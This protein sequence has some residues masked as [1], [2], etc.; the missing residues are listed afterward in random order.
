MEF[1]DNL[2][3]NN[4]NIK[5]VESTPDYLQLILVDNDFVPLL[6][7]SIVN[8]KSFISFIVKQ[9][10]RRIKDPKANS[11]S[12]IVAEK[13]FK[14][15]IKNSDVLNISFFYQLVKKEEFSKTM[16]VDL[17]YDDL[18][19][20]EIVELIKKI[21]DIFNFV[22]PEKEFKNPINQYYKDLI[23][24]GIIEQKDLKEEEKRSSLTEEEEIFL[25]IEMLLPAWKQ[26][27]ELGSEKDAK[28]FL[29]KLLESCENILKSMELNEDI[30]KAT[31]EYYKE[32]IE[33]IKDFKD[34][35]NQKNIKDDIDIK[36]ISNENEILYNNINL[37]HED[38]KNKEKYIK[39]NNNKQEDNQGLMTQ[40]QIKKDI[41]ELRK[42]PL[43][44]RLYF[45]KDEKI[46]GAEDEKTEFKNY[47]F[48][49]GKSKKEELIRQICSFINSSGGRLYIGI[50]DERS[51][52]GVP[53]DGD[54]K[55]Y[56][57]L[58][59]NMVKDFSPK[60]DPNEFLKFYA[61]PVKNNINGNI[62]DKLFVFKITIKKGDPYILYSSSSEKLNSTIRLQGQCANLT[63]EE[64]CKE[65][66]ERNKKKLS[67]KNINNN[68]DD[69]DRKEPS[70]TPIQ[71]QIANNEENRKNNSQKK[72]KVIKEYNIIKEKD[73]KNKNKINNNVNLIENDNDIDNNEEKNN[74]EF[75][76]VGLNKNN[77]NNEFEDFRN[78]NTN[79]KKKK[80]KKKN[81]KKNK[82]N[83][84]KVEV[85]NI[86]KNVDE[87][88]LNELFKDFNCDN[89]NF[90]RQQNGMF[91][92]YLD[93]QNE[94]DADNCIK[95]FNNVTLGERPIKLK[96]VT[97]N[98]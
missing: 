22:D 32:K 61:I 21:I 64:I 80:N 2:I 49:L 81:I 67:L 69:F 50:D 28:N 23:D 40:S 92:G 42:K 76:L 1:N 25:I 17:F 34:N 82:N 58:I 78:S 83:T 5:K 18:Y 27:R 90:Y 53:T 29:D 74:E 68:D 89:T 19:K 4:S 7:E 52:K 47:Y 59:F 79:N 60:I 26:Y 97:F 86:D 71:Q 37:E 56:N 33:E 95:T 8:Q 65:I 43:E 93:F 85:T 70:R 14:F 6:K 72:D 62:I 11:L 98:V 15:L 31:I 3:G 46:S 12:N 88:M 54:I 13:I 9:L 75:D 48:P 63:A 36:K 20:N 44:N 73:V 87:K 39:M 16:I 94:E 55:F 91:N 77:K 41:A 84:F 57:S 38:I 10:S 45:Y 24:Y 30:N 35:R 51:I 96:R 66:I